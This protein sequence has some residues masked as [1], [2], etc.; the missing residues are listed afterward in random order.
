MIFSHKRVNIAFKLKMHV[1]CIQIRTSTA[2]MMVKELKFTNRQSF[3]A[4]GQCFSLLFMFFVLFICLNKLCKP[5]NGTFALYWNFSFLWQTVVE[6]TARIL[7]I[8]PLSYTIIHCTRLWRR[9]EESTWMMN[10]SNNYVKK[11]YPD[12]MWY[13]SNPTRDIKHNLLKKYIY[14]LTCIYNI[15]FNHSVSVISILLGNKVKL[16]EKIRKKRN[17]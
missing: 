3:I 11:E 12:V 15:S 16:E 4:F 8:T 17:I 1:K 14:T 6:A 13:A 9:L 5:W 7:Y 2:L 10:I